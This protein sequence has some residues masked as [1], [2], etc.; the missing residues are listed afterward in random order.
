MSGRELSSRIV[1][2]VLKAVGSKLMTSA[3]AAA[4]ASRMACR[5]EPSPESPV[6]VTVKVLRTSRSS[7]ASRAS[8]RRAGRPGGAMRAERGAQA[9][10]RRIHVRVVTG[11]LHQGTFGLRYNGRAPSRARRP[12]AGRRG[13]AGSR[14][15]L[16][17]VQDIAVSGLGGPPGW[18]DRPYHF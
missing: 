14:Y 2:D 1:C 10:Q 15:L 17:L 12:G 18:S 16:D 11:I 6:F 4:L 9:N 3:P 5:S 7:S 13:V 8:R